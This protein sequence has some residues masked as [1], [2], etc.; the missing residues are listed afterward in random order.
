MKTRTKTKS[1]KVPD[2]VLTFAPL[3]KAL[4]STERLQ[5][6]RA[7]LF[8]DPKC[9]N[10]LRKTDQKHKALACKSKEKARIMAEWL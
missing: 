8:K 4:S 1:T 2:E 6:W 9:D 3:Q 5:K 7:K 10:N